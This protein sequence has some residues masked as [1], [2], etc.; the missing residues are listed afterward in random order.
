MKII[1]LVKQVPD[2]YEERK[3]DTATGILD[4]EASE[5]II[6]EIVERALETALSYKD[7]HKDTEIVLL[8]MGPDGVTASLRKGLSLGADSAIH[9]IDDNLSGSD[10]VRTSAVLAAALATT[11]YDLIIAGNESTDGRGGVM[12]AMVAEH[13]GLPHLTSI[14]SVEI[15]DT[16]IS[17]ARETENGTLDV[18]ASLPAVI[19]I[20][21]RAPEARF[22]N[23]KGIL[24]AKKKP[25]TVLSLGDL[26][27]AE[28][29]A[30]SLILST[31]ERPAREAG[32]KIIDEGNAG[33]EL[34]EFLVA[35][36]LI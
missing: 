7:S 18:H 27:V 33:V 9:V 21:E 32:T 11:D 14:D 5:P 10:L 36:H 20:T 29:S 22:P 15:T 12:P 35:G 30:H 31:A 24:G 23:F 13:L 3:L 6:D 19:S 1:V 8:S 25:I 17:G 16:A 28:P 2:T 4:R 26:S 34:A